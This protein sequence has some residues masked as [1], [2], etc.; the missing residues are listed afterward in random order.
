MNQTR[1]VLVQIQLLADELSVEVI[2]I[3]RQIEAWRGKVTG[4]FII[5]VSPEGTIKTEKRIFTSSKKNG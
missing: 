5:H 4:S 3:A 2:E 1:S